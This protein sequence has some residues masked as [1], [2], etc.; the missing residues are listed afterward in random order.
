MEVVYHKEGQRS[1]SV[2][3]G[4]CGHRG[5]PGKRCAVY[6]SGMPERSTMPLPATERFNQAK[7]L[8]LPKEHE[9]LPK[10]KYTVFSPHARGYRKGIHKVPKWTRVS[11]HSSALV[12]HLT[13]SSSLYGPT[14]RAFKVIYHVIYT[15]RVI[16]QYQNSTTCTFPAF[17]PCK[18][19]LK[20]RILP[21]TSSLVSGMSNTER[22]FASLY[23]RS[24]IMC[25]RADTAMESNSM[26]LIVVTE[27][28]AACSPSSNNFPSL[29]GVPTAAPIL[30]LRK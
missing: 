8:E 19:L 28:C 5:R 11:S 13:D 27:E 21:N 3:E 15:H 14:Q 16:I 7:A 29:P 12:F 25:V 2:E 18:M 1:C 10:D 30:V 9:M 20:E 26:R 6:R 22:L 24:I 23:E 4:R 17:M